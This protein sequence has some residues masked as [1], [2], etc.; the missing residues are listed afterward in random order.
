[1]DPVPTPE[2]IVVSTSG[3][4]A[5]AV[6]AKAVDPGDPHAAVTVD[7]LHSVGMKTKGWTSDSQYFWRQHSTQ[8]WLAVSAI[9]TTCTTFHEYIP[10]NWALIA[11]GVAA[12]G[13]LAGL[14]LRYRIQLSLAFARVHDAITR[15]PE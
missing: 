2:T 5:A 10:K 14:L 8:V 4:T 3:P 7:L 11:H 12:L 15:N 13:S 1:M 9:E 6:V